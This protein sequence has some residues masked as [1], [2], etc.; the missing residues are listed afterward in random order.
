[1]I[2]IH[3]RSNKWGHEALGIGALFGSFLTTI[4]RHAV[5]TGGMAR[6]MPTVPFSSD[7]RERLGTQELAPVL[8]IN[9]KD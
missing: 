2:Q 6:N 7:S 8:K 1:M 9:L 4:L 5:G 3:N